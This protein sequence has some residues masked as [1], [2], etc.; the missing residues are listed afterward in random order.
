MGGYLE[1]GGSKTWYD[2]Q[3]VG[4][5]LV[6]L[7][8]GL[9]TN[10]TWA[11]QMPDFAASF[12]VIAPERRG[13]GHSP[14]IEGPLSYDAMAADTIRFLSALGPGPVHLV[15]WSDGGIIGLLVAMAR[16]GLVQKLVVIG[17]NYHVSGL[18]PERLDA[19]AS[20][21]A[22][23]ADLGMLRTAYEAVSPDGPAHWPVVVAKVKEM[24]TTQ[25]T[26]QV[27]QLG[28]ISAPTLVV[29]GDDDLVTLEHT[30]SLFRA[31]PK[32]HLAVVPGAS[33]SVVMEKPDLL[34]R[35]VLDFLKEGPRAELPGSESRSS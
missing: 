29:V 7:H 23:S 26:I 2:E 27:E 11:A 6:L 32:A 21:D 8:G 20:L 5:P 28:D 15:G 22:G 34:N 17:A 31:I 3:G 30:V 18:I 1:V 4:D 24:A 33:H 10:A 16:P 19:F 25:P 35:L 12:R 13:H 9:S 14:D